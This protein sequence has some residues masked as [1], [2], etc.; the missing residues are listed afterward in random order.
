VLLRVLR[1]LLLRAVRAPLLLL[2]LW[3]LRLRRFEDLQCYDRACVTT[4]AQRATQSS[5]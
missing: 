1:Q 2:L 3:L 5:T 4:A